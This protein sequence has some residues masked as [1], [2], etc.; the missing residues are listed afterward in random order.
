MKINLKAMC[1]AAVIGVSV[2]GTACSNE[3]YMDKYK[4]YLDYSLENWEVVDDSV[5]IK[6]NKKYTNWIVKF[7]NAF[8]EDVRYA[9]SNQS[10]A[11]NSDDVFGSTVAVVAMDL[12][13]DELT[14]NIL[15]KNL[16]PNEIGRNAYSKND[17][18]F[19]AAFIINDL[20]SMQENYSKYTKSL[21]SA[22]DGIKLSEVTASNYLTDKPRF[23]YVYCM[24]SSED[25]AEQAKMEKSVDLLVEET[26]KYA[27]ENCNVIGILNFM[28]SDGSKKPI[29]SKSYIQGEEIIFDQNLE[30]NKESNA[31]YNYQMKVKERYNLD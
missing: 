22:T 11:K 12:V 23:A 30:E 10:D 25:K 9:F 20:E 29:Y 24:T 5:S 19:S 1:L 16:K 18:K 26:R 15:E 17:S 8:G 14:S 3:N 4:N 13:E 31:G 7:K 21:I 2:L 27:G 28:Y 6:D